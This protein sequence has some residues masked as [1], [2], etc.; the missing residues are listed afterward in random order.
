[1]SFFDKVG[2]IF[3]ESLF[4]LK[5]VEQ[6]DNEKLRE[7]SL[8]PNNVNIS[9]FAKYI[10]SAK[11]NT[12]DNSIKYENS[13]ILPSGVIRSMNTYRYAYK[14][15]IV[16]KAGE[17]ED[18]DKKIKGDFKTI[19]VVPS[20]FNPLYSIRLIGI[21]ENV[22][23]LNDS[24]GVDISGMGD[25]SSKMKDYI[26]DLSN[27][28]IKELVKLSSQ[29]NSILGHARYR[30]ADFMYCKDLGKIS[31]NHLITLRRFSD[32]IWDNITTCVTGKNGYPQ[33]I[34][35]DVGR[36]VTWFGTEDNKLENILKYTVKS[37]WKHLDAKIEEKA[38]EEDN[39]NRGAFGKIINTFSAGIIQASANGM[40]SNNNL[41]N[42]IAAKAF[43]GSVLGKYLP[44]NSTGNTENEKLMSNYD[45]NK[46]YEPKNTVQ[47]THIYEGKLTL[48][49]SITLKFCYKLRAYDN[50]NPKSAFLDLIG[51]I[52]AVTYRKG[53]FWGGSRKL[54]GTQRNEAA[55]KRVES[56]KQ[57]GISGTQDALRNMLNGEYDFNFN[58][59]KIVDSIKNFD[60]SK[61]GDFIKNAVS[62]NSFSG[63]MSAIAGNTLGRPA[64]YA[65]QS[66]LTGDAVGLWHLTIGNPK[67]P[68]ASIGNLILEEAT[69]EHSGEL[70]LDD[71]PTDLTVTVKLKPGRSRDLTEVSK[72]YTKGI[73]S[74]YFGNKV[75]DPSAFYDYN[76]SDSITSN[77]SNNTQIKIPDTIEP[78]PIHDINGKYHENDD[79]AIDKSNANIMLTNQL[80][81]SSIKDVSDEIA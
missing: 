58:F 73:S 50:I 36:L 15:P 80:Y 22:P 65:W 49:Q 9:Q 40:G 62:S 61:V 21:T 42:N 74:I 43:N 48:E 66:L 51:N 45:K 6:T 3:N 14:T 75:L 67:N 29:K 77:N 12:M 41:W 17:Y 60:P 1:M 10:S 25:E 24:Y 18:A 30:Y 34:F 7:F 52:L 39:E 70:G 64:R 53:E 79:I 16:F 68:I 54:I 57:K 63:I 56:I 37:S 44:Y 71:F 47:D 32:P 20:M 55:W 31:N 72:I 23:L 35:G 33:E 27:C 5:G 13:F 76:F 81:P 2:S 59:N 11:Q 28:S 78:I 8:N 46:V 19:S 4:G 69:I 38:S 26:K